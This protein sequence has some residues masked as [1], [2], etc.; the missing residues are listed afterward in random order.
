MPEARA[1]KSFQSRYG[2]IRAGTVFQC[3][4]DY[5]R[6]LLKNRLVAVEKADPAPGSNRSIPE[7]PNKGGK[8]GAAPGSSSP[9]TGQPPASGKGATLLSAPLGRASRKKTSSA[10]D[11]GESPKATKSTPAKKRANS[12]KETPPAE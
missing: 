2:M 3:E 9:G 12:K 7:A 10:S 11:G 4:P 1:L 6:A 8:D 5:L